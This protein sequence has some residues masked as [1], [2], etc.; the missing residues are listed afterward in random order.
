M[1]RRGQSRILAEEAARIRKSEQ[2]DEERKRLERIERNRHRRRRKQEETRAERKKVDEARRQRKMEQRLEEDK[3]QALVKAEEEAKRKEIEKAEEEQRE[4]EAWARAKKAQQTAEDLQRRER[5][6]QEKERL[7]KLEKER[8]KEQER[9]QERKRQEAVFKKLSALRPELEGLRAKAGPVSSWSSIAVA[10]WLDILE[11]SEEFTDEVSIAFSTHGI[12]GTAL[13]NL[14]QSKLESIM[15]N[16]SRKSVKFFVNESSVLL[17][18]RDF[19]V[20]V[21][22]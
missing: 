7:R 2:E 20:S 16:G 19:L 22:I 9:E 14:T 15:R 17:Q 21:D 10:Y 1:S 11:L 5:E 3:R 6:R 8:I 4:K 18:A 13:C 12:D